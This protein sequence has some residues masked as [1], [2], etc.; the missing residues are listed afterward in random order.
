MSNEFVGYPHEPGDNLVPELAL[1][2]YPSDL[3]PIREAV[4]NALDA[5]ATEIKIMH[6]PDKEITI[7]DNGDGIK[8]FAR[9]K[10]FGTSDKALDRDIK[11]TRQVGEKGL[12]KLSYLKLG[13]EV[14]FDTNN[15]EVGSKIKMDI[16]NIYLSEPR[17]YNHFLEHRGTKVTI[18]QLYPLRPSY[19]QELEKYL[20][21]VFS[22]VLVMGH[23]LQ[24]DK[25]P[26]IPLITLNGIKLE[27]SLKYD[28]RDRHQF[29]LK[30]GVQ[31]TGHLTEDKKGSGSIDV[32]VNHILITTKH[33]WLI[34]ATRSFSGWINCDAITPTLSR[35]DIS[36]DKISMEIFE[37][38]QADVARRFPK[39]DD[40]N[41]H[42]DGRT[43]KTL[44]EQLAKCLKF[45]D[46]N[47]ILKE[48]KGKVDPKGEE[49]K[50]KNE[51][52]TACVWPK[53]PTKQSTVVQSPRGKQEKPLIKVTKTDLG[54]LPPFEEMPAGQGSIPIFWNPDVK[55][56]I[57]NT[58]NPLYYVITKADLHFGPVWYRFAVFLVRAATQM[59]PACAEMSQTELFMYTDKMLSAII[60]DFGN[61]VDGLDN[62]KGF[63]D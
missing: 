49:G 11:G 40:V 37:R 25:K 31:V 55:K 54:N 60:L 8:N 22:Y 53:K 7:E 3:A 29:T 51:K 18:T 36:P 59:N 20:S 9:F 21:K 46:M 47:P 42:L 61:S 35:D 30:G 43:L 6:V 33:Q 38:L 45:M 4:S 10:K 52:A 50:R 28:F 14:W 39:K 23:E 48:P 63:L 34:D 1:K 12:G 62:F 27:A 15:G 17:K 24:R 57:V 58:T 41:K 2:A 19:P 5:G 16:Q 44:K 26:I 56:I 13:S 32:F